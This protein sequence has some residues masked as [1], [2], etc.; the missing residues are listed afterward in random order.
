MHGPRLCERFIPATSSISYGLKSRRKGLRSN[1]GRLRAKR[2]PWRGIT[3]GEFT[4]F[5]APTLCD[6]YGG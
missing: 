3:S 2:A 1:I 4:P 6:P 5:A